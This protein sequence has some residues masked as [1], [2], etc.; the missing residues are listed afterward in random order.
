M[1]KLTVLLLILLLEENYSILVP[2]IGKVDM[3]FAVSCSL[4][5]NSF[6]FS[7]LSLKL[8]KEHGYWKIF[9]NFYNMTINCAKYLWLMIHWQ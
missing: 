5:V 2:V 6:C 3:S 1:L 4:T 8:D 9:C 7:V